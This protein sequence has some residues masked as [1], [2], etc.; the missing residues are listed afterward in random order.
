MKDL[1]QSARVEL[2]SSFPI[3]SIGMTN[4]RVLLT[5]DERTVIADTVV[6]STGFRPDHEIVSELR[7]DLDPI[8]SISAHPRYSL[9]PPAPSHRSSTRTSRSVVAAL[10]GNWEA[11]R[12]VQLNLPQTAICSSNLVS[13]G[14]ALSAL[15]DPGDN[16][17]ETG[18]GCGTDPAS[19]RNL[20]RPR[21]GGRAHRRTADRHRARHDQ[22]R[23]AAAADQPYADSSCLQGIWAHLRFARDHFVTL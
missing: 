21:P 7:L 13:G 19:R 4:G 8:R 3:E 2:I 23:P 9:D 22:N 10:A 20:R 16:A 18:A 1:V 6:N 14:S 5:S 15:G 12:T 11:A 17:H